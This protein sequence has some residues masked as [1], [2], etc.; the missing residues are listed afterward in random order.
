MSDRAPLQ[1]VPSAGAPLASVAAPAPARTRT[2]AE[3]VEHELMR[4]SVTPPVRV[5][6]ELEIGAPDDPLEREADDVADAVMR[7]PD[8]SP[9]ASPSI[10]RACA[11]CDEEKVQRMGEPEDSEEDATLRA[12]PLGS[13]VL[14]SSSG[15]LVASGQAAAQVAEARQGGLPLSGVDREFFQPRLG[16]DLSAVRVH[17]GPEAARAA[18]AV[19][20]RAFTVGPDIV[21]GSGQPA[22]SSDAGRRL[23]AHE[24][25]HVVQQGHAPALPP[26]G[27]S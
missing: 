17:A 5:Q 8:P 26:E 27:E 11:E 7:M 10:Q 21:F 2:G 19:G 23:L 14:A 16:H 20:A 22:P 24:L 12:A 3:P 1:H 9:A 25:T 6:A 4:M 15:G 18:A 13:G